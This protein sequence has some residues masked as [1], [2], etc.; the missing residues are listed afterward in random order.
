MSADS[1]TKERLSKKQQRA[2][3]FRKAVK[4]GEKYVR[5]EKEVSAAEHALKKQAKEAAQAEKKEKARMAA[6]KKAEAE[7]T[8]EE[9]E[10]KKFEESE[11]AAEAIKTKRKIS[12]V[13][14]GNEDAATTTTEENSTKKKRKTGYKPRFIL[15]IGNLPYAATTESLSKH[16]AASKPDEIRLAT[17]KATKKVKGYAFAEFTGDDASI[18]M[19]VCLRL[20]HTELNG[21]KINVEL[22][23]GGGGSGANRQ[24]KLKT[25]NE[26]LEQERR[27]IQ[28]TAKAVAK[29]KKEGAGKS[30]GSNGVHES[31]LHLLQ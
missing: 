8:N 15:F 7:K 1:S 31:R 2:N 11:K 26:G 9:E 4:S 20:H 14:E 23:A 25:K 18:R 27:D 21:R 28:T 13:D 22:T 6:E 24:A 10:R 29:E 16:L 5:P 30:T 19:N 12:E 3:L 17:D